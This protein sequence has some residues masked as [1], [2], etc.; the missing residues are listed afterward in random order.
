M[1]RPG[2]VFREPVR[3]NNVS[4]IV[5]HQHPS[6]DCT[7]SPEDVLITSELRRAGTIF[8]IELLDSMIVSPSNY[9]S[10]RKRGLG[11]DNKY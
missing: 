7:T 4:V 6:G 5:A 9:V 2:E 11:F 1:V 10:L 3:L 8:E